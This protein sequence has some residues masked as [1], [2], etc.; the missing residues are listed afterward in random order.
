MP[1][2]L[3][4]GKRKKYNKITTF[5]LKNIK[6]SLIKNQTFF[7]L[8]WSNLN[9]DYIH[10]MKNIGFICDARNIRSKF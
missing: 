1:N 5:S 8:E 4:F 7:F 9:A 3:N 10:F 2:N 6:L